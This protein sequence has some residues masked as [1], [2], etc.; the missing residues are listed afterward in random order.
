MDETYRQFVTTLH[1]FITDINRY[2]S[3]PGCQKFLE[4]FEKLDMDKVIKRYYTLMK[5][6]HDRLK[7]KDETIFQQPLLIFPGINLSDM[8]AGFNSGQKT[9]IWIYLQIL[10]VSSE[11][12]QT[13]E[14][15]NTPAANQQQI[16]TTPSETTFDPFV[17]VGS[18]DT[19]FSITDLHSGPDVLPGMEE[20]S[21]GGLMESI[22]GGEM[23]KMTEEFQ[24]MTD[25][26]IEEASTNIKSLLGA[27]VNPALSNI[28]SEML[29]GIKDELKNTD[30]TKKGNPLKNMM[31][32]AETVANNMKPKIESSDVDMSQFMESAQNLASSVSG[33]DGKGIFPAGFNPFDMMRGIMK[34]DP[35]LQQGGADGPP[36]T[37]DQFMQ[38]YQQML[39][40]MGMPNFD[41]SKLMPQRKK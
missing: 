24:N 31:K 36:M 32:V 13:G 18:S 34:N 17:G 6:I 11:V 10:F 20:T 9:K 14:N 7:A 19:N 15:K 25:D 37:E 26:Q 33:P 2:I 12:L 1:K 22:L 40:S 28:I 5:P 41:L 3:T 4:V 16:V 27:N 38:N 35:N 30:K 29:V 8:W 21:S 39:G 23:S